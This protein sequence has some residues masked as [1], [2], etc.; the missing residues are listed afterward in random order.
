MLSA[1]GVT[2]ASPKAIPPVIISGL[3]LMIPHPT[4]PG[5]STTKTVDLTQLTHESLIWDVTC[6][7]QATETN[8]GQFPIALRVAT[9]YGSYVNDKIHIPKIYLDGNDIGNDDYNNPIPLNI[10]NKS[11]TITFTYVYPFADPGDTPSQLIFMNLDST[12]DFAITSCVANDVII[13]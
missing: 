10:Y 3:P 12:G 13:K 4:Q 6:N 7:Y 11:G 5:T 8:Q 2:Y 1:Y 9:E